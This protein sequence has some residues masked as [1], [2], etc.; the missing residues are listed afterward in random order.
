MKTA[1]EVA[2]LPADGSFYLI[3][4]KYE[5][6]KT[7][8]KSTISRIFLLIL[9]LALI[10]TAI[11]S[12]SASAEGE[13][14]VESLEIISQNVSYEGQTHLFYAVSYE[15]VAT[16]EAITLEVMWT[17]SEGEHTATV[18]E[19][20]SEV[21]EG[22]ACR[23]FKTPGVDAKNFTQKFTVVAK[24]EDGT[25]S[26]PK[27][28]SVAEYCNLWITYVAYTS[29]T[30]T[31]TEED[32][33]LSEAC[34]ATLAY[35]S[36]IQKHLKYYPASNTADHPEN[37]AYVKAFDGTVNGGVS[38]HVI[39]GS[40]VA[41][42]YT[43][44]LESG[45]AVTGWNIYYADGTTDTV[46]ASGV[47]A[48]KANCVAEAVIEA[49]IPEFVAGNGKYFATTTYKGNRFDYSD[50]SQLNIIEWTP[51]GTA[52][53]AIAITDGQLV[54]DKTGVS[55]YDEYIFWNL[56]GCSYRDGDLIIFETDV[57]FSPT[58]ESGKIGYYAERSGSGVD[59]AVNVNVE[60]G[61]IN[62]GGAG[63]LN[64]D[65]WYNVTI[66]TEIDKSADSVKVHVYVNGAYAGEAETE[67]YRKDDVHTG[68]AHYYIDANDAGAV[69]FDNLYFG[70]GQLVT[71]NGKYFNDTENYGSLFRKDYEDGVAQGLY[72]GS[73]SV[74]SSTVV[75]GVNRF[76]NLDTNGT[77]NT[78]GYIEFNSYGNSSEGCNTFIFEADYYVT[79]P[80]N[81]KPDYMFRVFGYE[82]NLGS[83]CWSNKA[84]YIPHSGAEIL[85]D[86]WY[87]LRIEITKTETAGTFTVDIYLDDVLKVDGKVVT[88]SVYDSCR[89]LISIPASQN[90]DVAMYFDNVA[91]G[92][93]NK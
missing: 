1:Q 59:H 52:A 24:T 42:S 68:K 82:F 73:E 10:I 61:K 22:K 15:N 80:W 77:S 39:K 74:T 33:N 88:G 29:A 85:L 91:F 46:D 2:G 34:K 18:T 5:R 6:K 70:Y 78:T 38:G 31:P 12:V 3:F 4:K 36:A 41:L 86:T 54:F 89:N 16:P 76:Q 32:V 66:A 84:I 57:K 69:T 92:Y 58:V 79:G 81:T 37:Y 40:E 30:G 43:G 53:A 35:G 50:A 27:T 56:T 62:I 14:D 51:N 9:S 20:E 11:F 90:G 93:I 47:F 60:D 83:D 72:S 48:P 28:F 64:P 17:D 65:T 8:K 44:A 55:Q 67:I 23:T 63:A 49:A 71:G 26:A 7:M 25:V 75:D 13:K 87:N 45:K 19:S 21:V